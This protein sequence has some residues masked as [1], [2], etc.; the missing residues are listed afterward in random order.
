MWILVWV[1]LSVAIGLAASRRYHRDGAGWFFISLLTSPLIGGLFLIAVGPKAGTR[2]DWATIDWSG[3]SE[4]REQ[5]ARE[6]RD[7][8]I[9]LVSTIVAVAAAATLYAM[10][11]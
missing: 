5:Q 3:Q 4:V 1:L 6:S 9:L 2:I 11:Q 8:I 10:V 7:N